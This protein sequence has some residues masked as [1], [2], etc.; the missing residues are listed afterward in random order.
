MKKL[1]K[2][3]LLT[4]V[5]MLAFAANSLLCRQALEHTTIDPALFTTVRV[6]SGALMLCGIL[7]ARGNLTFWRSGSWLSA[8]ALVTYA[9]CFSFAYVDLTAATGALLLFAAVQ[10]TMLGVGFY[11]GERLRKTQLF[12]LV[13]AFSGFIVLLYPG[14]RSPPLV[15]SVLMLASGCAWGVYSL[16]S[17]SADPLATTGSNFLR[18]SPLSILIL[19]V[20]SPGIVIDPQGILFAIVSGA[21]ASG[22]GYAIWYAAL[23]GLTVTNAA[24]VQLSVPVITAA[25]AIFS[26]GEPIDIRFIVAS[27]AIL[28]GVAIV[29]RERLSFVN[30]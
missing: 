20:A 6:A 22:C 30:K 14:L 11:H 16:R 15:G 10:S 3:T 23:K 9:T 21:L 7:I 2:T 13:V 29:I 24:T 1:G 27:I 18:A 26:L 17:G 12:A 4:I 28:G 5:A 8:I 25:V 19:F